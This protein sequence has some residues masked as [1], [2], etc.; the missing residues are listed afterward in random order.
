MPE[1]ISLPSF[2]QIPEVNG[3]NLDEFGDTQADGTVLVSNRARW[4][5][6][7]YHTQL[8]QRVHGTTEPV[9]KAVALT[10]STASFAPVRVGE[11][12]EVRA[13]HFNSEN[14]YGP[15]TTWVQNLIDGDLTP[16]EDPRG[17]R[18][19]S[20]PEGWRV[21]WDDVVAEDYKDSWI[22]VTNN[23]GLGFSESFYIDKTDS[24]FMDRTGFEEVTMV[25]VWVQHVDNSGNKSNAVA[26]TGSTG[27]VAG[28]NLPVGDGTDRGDLRIDDNGNLAIGLQLLQILAGLLSRDP[29]LVPEL[30]ITGPDEISERDTATLEAMVTGGNY[31]EIEYSWEI[32][33][34]GGTLST[35]SE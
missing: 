34:G 10:G 1:I 21:H 22:F 13:R 18:F 15:W 6:Q 31:D 14:F 24:T 12:Y 29:T 19:T 4:R 11:T 17:L 33:S 27:K 2:R 8:E 20:I 3:L 5:E 26:I 9:E 28:R 30:V 35:P 23:A 7:P 25:K 32:I 16:P